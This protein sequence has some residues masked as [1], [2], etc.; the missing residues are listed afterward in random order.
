MK[1]KIPLI[2]IMIVA[3]IC[4]INKEEIKDMFSGDQPVICEIC[5]DECPCPEADCICKVEICK[6]PKCIS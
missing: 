2:A 1:F 6:C 3:A 4:L 5:A